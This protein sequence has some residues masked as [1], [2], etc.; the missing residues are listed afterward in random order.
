VTTLS[1][2]LMLSDLSD[3]EARRF[4]AA[5]SRWVS[6]E[7]S[8]REEA[9]AGKLSSP[10]IEKFKQLLK[11]GDPPEWE[12]FF[13]TKEVQIGSSQIYR[14]LKQMREQGLRRFDWPD[15]V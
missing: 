4:A 8:A 12:F 11:T 15:Q 1:Q 5:L 3:A 10:R 6:A 7:I 14:K 13:Y 2:S 9:A